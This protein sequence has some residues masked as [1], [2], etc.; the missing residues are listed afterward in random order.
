[1]CARSE[2]PNPCGGDP[3]PP[4]KPVGATAP[5]ESTAPGEH[6][7]YDDPHPP[8][9]LSFSLAPT[10]LDRRRRGFHFAQRIAEVRDIA[11]RSIH[12]REAN[13]GDLVERVQLLHH[14]L[15]DLT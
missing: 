2:S 3:D 11:E 10:A 5:V 7:R 8:R 4:A 14:H 9:T 13:V 12:R 6:R 1:M 15:A